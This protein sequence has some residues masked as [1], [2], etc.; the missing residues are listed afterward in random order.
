MLAM[1]MGLTSSSAMDRDKEG[2]NWQRRRVVVYH[3]RH[4]MGLPGSLRRDLY[5]GWYTGLVKRTRFY[6]FF[7]PSYLG[8]QYP[9]QVRYGQIFAHFL[10]PAL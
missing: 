4:P 10:N 6:P 9:D 2:P 3:Q 8:S 1:V 5:P 7:F